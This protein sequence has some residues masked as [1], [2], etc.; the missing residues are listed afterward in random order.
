MRALLGAVTL[1][2][3]VGA[4]SVAR[5]DD[6]AQAKSHFSIGARAYEERKFR[7]AI[8]AFEESYRLAPRPAI[9]FSIAQAYKRQ[10]FLEKLDRDLLQ[11]ISYYR[12]YLEDDAKG[13]RAGEA[14]AA[15]GD[16]EPVA[17]R[18]GLERG[19]AAPAPPA[20]EGPRPARILVAPSVRNATAR[21][22]GGAPLELPSR[23][24]VTPGK[25]TV[26]IE[27][28][29]Y[30]PERREV[31]VAAGESFPIDVRLVERPALLRFDVGDGVRVFVDGR[32]A[33]TTP[34]PKPLE[35]APGG[36]DLALIRR[37]HDPIGLHVELGPGESRPVRAEL[38]VSSQRV[39]AYVVLGL[40]GLV[41][42]GGAVV[43]GLAFSEQSRAREIE[44]AAAKRNI[45]EAER[46]EQEDA[47]ERRNV[48]RASSLVGV[49]AGAA[50]GLTAAL[51]YV[52]DE[53]EPSA[54]PTKRAPT[55][56]PGPVDESPSPDLAVLPFAGPTTVGAAISGRF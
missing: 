19:G 45:T 29:G 18:L 3:A 11:A 22:D 35:I 34:L 54:V 13:K 38:A 15:L 41:T 56:K 42:V 52:L 37:G 12:R 9:L 50:L 39:G 51:L 48:L 47:L 27:A 4:T 40:A 10:Y 30:L 32:E 31:E 21:V 26:L 14:S 2:I 6:L 36:Y 1:A 25:H 28:E 20:P 55:R 24:E 46:A 44:D 53:P 49:A 17:L 33:A 23:I 43:G 5:A 7:M 16:L 8:D